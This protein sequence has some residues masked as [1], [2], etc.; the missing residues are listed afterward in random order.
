M[1]TALLLLLA[2]AGNAAAQTMMLTPD[3][4]L[5]SSAPDLQAL[6][7]LSKST[8]PIVSAAAQNA[9]GKVQGSTE[10]FTLCAEK[11]ANFPLRLICAWK[12]PEATLRRLPPAPDAGLRER[13]LRNMAIQSLI[14]KQSP[15]ALATAVAA[16]GELPELKNHVAQEGTKASPYLHA[17]V[18]GKKR[19]LSGI[20]ATL[21]AGQDS[22]TEEEALA[23]DGGPDAADA[24]LSR[25][26]QYGGLLSMAITERAREKPEY[27]PLAYDLAVKAGDK[28]TAALFPDVAAA[29]EKAKAVVLETDFDYALDQIENSFDWTIRTELR[30]KLYK[31]TPSEAEQFTRLLALADNPHDIFTEA[32]ETA[33][34]RAKNPRFLP[35]IRQCLRNGGPNAAELC[36]RLA[37]FL[38]DRE[39]APYL[40]E[41]LLPRMTTYTTT[42]LKQAQSSALKALETIEGNAARDFMVSKL[43]ALDGDAELALAREAESLATLLSLLDAPNLN[44]GNRYALSTGDGAQMAIS[45]V[46]QDSIAGALCRDDKPLYA[47]S[48]SQEAAVTARTGKPVEEICLH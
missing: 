29:R 42:E 38:K 31:F 16:L 32:A 36:A 11:E 23:L 3:P 5:S 19:T 10:T 48:E 9:L 7:S 14:R 22:F 47:L 33:L 18:K 30:D 40:K 28:Q 45:M 8:D 2:C 17:A 21:L 46:P 12:A 44:D 35:Q 43:G 6:F 27:R 20:A 4:R 13:E 24:F 15:D 41:L 25:F 37:G 39:A 34:L 1:R 26:G